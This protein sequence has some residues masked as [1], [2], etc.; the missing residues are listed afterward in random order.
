[1]KAAYIISTLLFRFSAIATI[2]AIVLGIV[3]IPMAVDPMPVL[4]VIGPAAI[5]GGALTVTFKLVANKAKLS[6]L[7]SMK[8]T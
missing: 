4:K 5:L 7:E 6:I 3:F 1:M 2:L 8:N